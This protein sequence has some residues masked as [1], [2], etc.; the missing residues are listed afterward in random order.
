MRRTSSTTGS[1]HWVIFASRQLISSP[2]QAG[3][4][5]G[6]RVGC[7]LCL[8][9]IEALRGRAGIP[10]SIPVALMSSSM[11]GQCTPNPLPMNSKLLRWAD[12]ASDS[13]HDQAKGTLMVRPSARWATIESSVTCISMMRGVSLTRTRIP[14]AHVERARASV[15][16]SRSCRKTAGKGQEHFELLA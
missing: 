1:C 13:R 6:L 3:A 14:F 4:V 2:G 12:V 15:H 11:S 9:R 16:C 8:E 7:G 10:K 5:A